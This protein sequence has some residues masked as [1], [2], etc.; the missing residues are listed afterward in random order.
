MRSSVR[1]VFVAGLLAAA[2][3]L[4][5]EPA[6]PEYFLTYSVDGARRALS[7]PSGSPIPTVEYVESQALVPDVP[8]RLVIA[9][10][11]LPVAAGRFTLVATGNLLDQYIVLVALGAA[12]ESAGEWRAAEGAWIEIDSIN[13]ESNAVVGRFEGTLVA[14]SG[15]L[16]AQR[17]LTGSFRLPMMQTPLTTAR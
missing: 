15:E 13:A 12:G 8:E 1:S 2:C 3:T 4:G 17:A 9:T 11:Q 7:W 16:P 10:W 5:T 14:A 6:G